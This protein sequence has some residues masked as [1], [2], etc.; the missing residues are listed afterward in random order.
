MMKKKKKSSKKS[1]K[2]QKKAKNNNTVS[3]AHCMPMYGQYGGVHVV[4]VLN[5]LRCRYNVQT[6]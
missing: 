3:N 6:S 1:A 4:S 5:Y 2:G